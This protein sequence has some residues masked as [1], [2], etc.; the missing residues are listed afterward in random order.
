MTLILMGCS[1][2][3]LAPPSTSAG[4][5]PEPTSTPTST[6]A[7][8][9]ECPG[10]GD[11]GEG[12]AIDEVDG[13]GSDSGRLGSIG[14]HSTDQC[15]SFDFDFET[16]EG[17]PATSVPSIQIAHLESF[18]VIRISMDV[19]ASVI[20]D[21]LVETPLVDRLFVVRGLDG[22]LFVDLHLVAPA[23]ARV[24]VESSPAR[25]TVDL[26]PGLVP[27]T[28]V[29]TVGDDVVVISPPV[30]AS[31]GPSARFMG[32]DRLPDGNVM[33]IA[34][35][36]DAVVAEGEVSSDAPAGTWGEFQAQLSLPGGDV[37][38]FFGA[39][40]ADNGNLHGITV[41]VTVS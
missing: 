7:P 20:T 2:A 8:V 4:T 37:S 29:S 39:S 34:T 19:A 16:S 18:Q 3:N 11:F 5:T 17:A 41:E 23:A 6:I 15:E 36:G 38:V 25:L 10:A 22:R 14:W 21:Q 31:I 27:F 9:V 35:Q 40:D 1:G 30:G 32:Y 26:R 33:V 28:G 24:R 13:E 12:G